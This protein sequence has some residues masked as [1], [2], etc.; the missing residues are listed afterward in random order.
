[1]IESRIKEIEVG[2]RDLASELI[3]KAPKPIDSYL[4]TKL[5]DLKKFNNNIDGL[6]PN[7]NDDND[8][9]FGGVPI[10]SRQQQQ[11]HQQQQQQQDIFFIYINFDPIDNF[12]NYNNSNN[13]NNNLE[14]QGTNNETE[15]D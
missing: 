14:N 10:I 11:Q 4:Q 15:R 1:M 13:V 3:K 7:G 8:S 9:N 2:K 12:N 6:I 5:A